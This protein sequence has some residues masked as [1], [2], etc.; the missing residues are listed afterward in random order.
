MKVSLESTE[1][2][3]RGLELES[4]TE[5]EKAI[6]LDIWTRRGRPVVFGKRGDAYQ[7]TIAPVAEEVEQPEDEPDWVGARHLNLKNEESEKPQ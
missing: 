2:Q 1:L 5:E 3:N 4:E 7:L 6:L